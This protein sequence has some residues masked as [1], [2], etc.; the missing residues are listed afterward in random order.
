MPKVVGLLCICQTGNTRW[1]IN[2]GDNSHITNTDRSSMVLRPFDMTFVFVVVFFFNPLN[3]TC[4]ICFIA[5]LPNALANSKAFFYF[6]FF[7]QPPLCHVS[8]SVILMEHCTK[9][10]DFQPKHIYQFVNYS[11]SEQDCRQFCLQSVLC[12]IIKKNKIY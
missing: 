8:I 4:N 1:Y 7:C 3:K 6:Y 2:G 11:M 12:S 9:G 10:K 5:Y